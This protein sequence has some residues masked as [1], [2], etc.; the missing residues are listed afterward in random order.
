VSAVAAVAAVTAL[1]GNN[2]DDD[3]R[4]WDL[5]MSSSYRTQPHIIS[6]GVLALRAQDIGALPK[7]ATQL[8]GNG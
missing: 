1:F 7:P 2:W 4:K 3:Q 8:Q 6:G 5:E